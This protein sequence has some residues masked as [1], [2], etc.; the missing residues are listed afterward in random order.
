M[1]L[2]FTN[3][4]FAEEDGVV[5]YVRELRADIRGRVTEYALLR[6]SGIKKGD[7]IKGADELRKYMAQKE[8][9][10]INRRELRE[11]HIV[12]TEEEPDSDGRVP[13]D[14]TIHAADTRNF[15]I[16]PEPRYSSNTGWSPTLRIRDFNFLGLMTPLKINFTYKYNDGESVTYSRNNVTFLLGMEIPFEAFGLG[17]NFD[18]EHIFSYYFGEPFLYEGAGGI[19]VDIPIKTTTLTFGLKQKIHFGKEYESWQKHVYNANFED[20]R[21]GSSRIYG[22]WKAPLPFETESLGSLV[23]KPSLSTGINYAFRGEDLAEHKGLT[24]GISQK[25]GFNKIDW[26][27]NFRRGAD[28]YLENRNEYSFFLANWNN[29]ITANAT[30]HLIITDFFGISVRGR[31][32]RWFYNYDSGTDFEDNTEGGGWEAAGMIRGVE[33]GSIFARYMLLF[34]FDF[35]FHAFTFMFSEYFKDE[36][37]RLIDFELQAAPV[38]DIAVID[39]IELDNKRNFIRDI[40][41]HNL[42]AGGGV[43]LLFFPLSFRSIYLCASAVW[44]LNNLF[45]D[46]TLPG[47][48]DLELYIGFGRHY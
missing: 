40:R 6:N 30:L 7:E 47:S 4:L 13:V 20:A 36:R 31:F 18:T 39:G 24:A 45:S 22:E 41:P 32:T 10:L 8:Q 35:T 17:W 11:A 28:L 37:L 21:Y 29:S 46:G 5:Y 12:F 25:L 26:L 48:S 23:Y 34:N 16:V 3:A 15:I 42:I 44:N 33:D 14:I 27:G 9:T 19:S 43:E 2:S 38:I 1:L